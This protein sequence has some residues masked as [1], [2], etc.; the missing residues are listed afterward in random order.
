M[1]VAIVAALALTIGWLGGV[2]TFR[3]TQRWCPVCGVSL[4]CPG[5]H[6]AAPRFPTSE[7]FNGDTDRNTRH[8]AP[9][10]AW[11]TPGTPGLSGTPGTPAHV[12][13]PVGDRGGPAVGDR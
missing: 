4:T 2:L 12:H 8:S 11:R 3:V 1:G 10:A 6:R 5:G 13:F 7:R 9:A